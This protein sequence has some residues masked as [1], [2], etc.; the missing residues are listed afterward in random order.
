MRS[1]PCA[2]E[3]KEGEMS[4]MFCFTFFSGHLVNAINLRA[5]NGDC[6]AFD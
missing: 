5:E 6:P 2:G 1:G 4:D 3:Q